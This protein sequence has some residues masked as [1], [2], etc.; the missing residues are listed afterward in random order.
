[1]KSKVKK[2]VYFFYGFW[3]FLSFL[4]FD[5]KKIRNAEIVCFFPFYQ[6]GGAEKVHLNII[7][8]LAHKNVCV[9]FTLN[10]ATKN[11]QE[12]FKANAQCIEINLIL[13]KRNTFV[14]RLLKKSIYK[15]INTSNN[16]KAVFGSNATYF[17]Q[18]LP[19]ISDQI[20]RIDLFHAFSKPDSRELEVV[21][22]VKYIDKR[23]VINQNTK[24]DLLKIYACNNI[25]TQYH[26]V[27]QVI[28]NGIAIENHE[29]S[30]K[31]YSTIK[32]GYVGRWSDEKRPEL[33]LAIAKS[34]KSKYP[35][36]SF[37]MAGTGMKSN[38]NLITDAGVDFLG[39]ITDKKILNELY[40]ELHFL[41]LPSIYEGFPLVIM[42]SMAYG[43]IPIATDL[44]GI[45]EHITSDYNGILINE[46]DEVKIIQAF[47]N[48]ITQFIE[49][50]EMR[51]NLA[52]NCFSY[53]HKNFGL[54]KFNFSYQ[55][56]LN[57]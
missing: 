33:F 17:Y 51:N 55:K 31:D 43:V 49:N 40:D 16:C 34:I 29:F 44:D 24:K 5:S 15:A 53:A 25:G 48:S 22:S 14:S 1:M 20:A 37:V 19:F 2:I 4:V 26:K 28:E 41:I 47:C 18:I 27:I 35:S 21:N 50:P 57:S 12:Q 9:I 7:K 32:V 46:S 45:R 54:E 10:S 38:L 8:A 13:N 23:V 52:E 36:I 3:N 39:E 11:F 6:T 42:E 56:L 30:S